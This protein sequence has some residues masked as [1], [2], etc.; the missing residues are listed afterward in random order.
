[1]TDV[2]NMND[3]VDVK[4]IN[5]IDEVDI[6]VIDDFPPS[7]ANKQKSFVTAQDLQTEI[8]VHNVDEAAKVLDMDWIDGVSTK[9]KI[10]VML[11][12]FEDRIRSSIKNK[13]TKMLKPL[14]EAKNILLRSEI[15]K[16][17][18]KDGR[19]NLVG[20]IPFEE[21]CISCKGTGELYKFFRTETSVPCKF[22]TNGKPENDGY[23]FIQCHVCK[24]TKVYEEKECPNCYRDPKTDLPTGKEQIKCRAC[25][26]HA[27]FHKWPI[28]SKIKSTT[29]CRHCKG[30][31]FT[32][33]EPPPRKP[34]KFNK[35][36]SSPK[37][38][39]S[40]GTPVIS[41]QLGEQLKK[42]KSLEK[43]INTQRKKITS[44][45]TPVISPQLGEKLKTISIKE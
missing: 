30:R 8:S 16:M 39:S 41:A 35:I 4:K 26:G 2:N 24:G 18:E 23:I 5:N 3:R 45:I 25:R 44:F 19:F 7:N 28:D 10:P 20:M 21:A 11:S 42:A 34:K 43:K 17:I 36:K 15:E 22:C 27:I 29:H 6:I 40:F 37:H 13:K 9:Y 32:L 33:P 31:G 38:I 14:T 12:I 1:M